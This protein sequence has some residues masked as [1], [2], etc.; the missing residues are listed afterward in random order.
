VALSLLALK[1]PSA[2]VLQLVRLVSVFLFAYA[3]VAVLSASGS[4]RLF[5]AAFAAVQ[6]TV[7]HGA[8]V[9]VPSQFTEWLQEVYSAYPPED[10]YSSFRETQT[11]YNQLASCLQVLVV[12]TVAGYIVPWVVKWRQNSD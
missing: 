4:R 1:Y 10:E 8:S 12:A 5:W 2:W 7:M 9:V 11:Q 6:F 3:L